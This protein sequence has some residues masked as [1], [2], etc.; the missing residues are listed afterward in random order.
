MP[1]SSPLPEPDPCPGKGRVRCILILA[2]AIIVGAVGG[3]SESAMM[4]AAPP[5]LVE[6]GVPSFVV[7]GPDSLGFSTAPSDMHLLPDG[8]IL[9]V[10]QRQIAIGDGTRWETYQQA[11]DQDAYIYAQ[12]AVDD[13]GRIYTGV[14]GKI[15]RID[16]GADALWR[17]VPV[18]STPDNDPYSRVVQVAGTWVWRSGGGTMLA[19][20]PGRP[21]QKCGLSAAVEDIFAVGNDLFASNGSSG[22]LYEL[23]F[24]AMATP[25]PSVKTVA[26]DIVTCSANYGAR[27]VIVGTTG[28]GIRTF[29]GKEFGDVVLPKILSEGSHINDICQVGIDLYAAA[30]DTKGIVFFERGGRIVQVL[31]GT[32]DHRLARP[33]RLVYSKNGVL[34][35]MLENAVACIQFPSPI[36]N[37]EALLP[38]HMNY[39]K[40]LRHDGKLWVLADG[41]LTRGIYDSN[42]C[43][44]RF[45]TD[46]PPGKFLWSIAETKGR[47]FA[48]NDEGIFVRDDAA[49]KLVAAG[50]VNARLGIGPA[51]SE[52][53]YFYV[54][55]DEVGWIQ[56]SAGRFTAQRIPVKGLGEVY[57]AVD[58][59]DGALWLELGPHR[60]ARVTFDGNKP[61]VRMFGRQDGLGNG[62]INIFVLDGRVHCTSSG[63][64]QRFDPQTQRFV[65]DRQLSRQFPALADSTGRPE[66]DSTGRLWFSRHG[67][68]CYIDD[69][70][71]G[72]KQIVRTLA[73][74]FEPTE[75]NMQSDGVIW[76]QGREHLI[77]YDPHMPSPPRIP[78]RAEITSVLLTASNLHLFTPGAALRPLPY[79]DNSLLI[80]FA[81]VTY[82]FGP[83]LSFEVMLE[84]AGNRWVS[85][86]A[87][88]SASFTRLKEGSYV[89]HVRPVIGETPGQE[90]RLAFTIQ[91]PWFRTR[92]AWL[93]YL[94]VAIGLVTSIAWFSS[95]MQRREKIRL[96][97]LV[98]ERTAEL[99]VNNAQLGRQVQEITEKTAAL[100]AS[101]ERYRKLNAELESRVTDRTAQLSRSNADLKREIAERQRAEQE[102]ERVHKQLVS[103]S[104]EAG[105]A[106]VATGV[107]H[108]VG[109]VLNSVNVSAGLLAERMHSSKINGVARLAQLLKEQGDGLG[110]FFTEDPRGRT[111]PGYLEQLAA[112]MEQERAEAGKEVEGLILNVNHIKEIVAMQQNYARVSG[113]VETVAL[114]EMV[115]DAIKIHGGAYA[116]HGIRLERDFEKLPP[117]TVDKHKLLQILV[118]LLHNSKYACEATNL[119]DKRVTI[120][121]KAASPEGAILAVEDTGTGIQPENMPRIFTQGFTTRKTGHGF[122]LHSAALA[123]NELGGRLTAHSDGPGRG[124][125]FTLWLP[126]QPPPSGDK[127]L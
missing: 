118:N 126:L 90:A 3:R 120:R 40:P 36:S 102:V 44:Q 86:G 75:F 5:G 110:R 113:V 77:R 28:S 61:V 55:R 30:V 125:T 52:G 94:A 16:L 91:P 39:A 22:G 41:H 73:L 50:I 84:G 15:C 72:E 19:W 89:F 33:R 106:E 101:E 27:Q 37:F 80:R 32:L 59:A 51:S 47:F 107:L 56:E 43:L 24:G 18:Y 58:T 17:L 70:K 46:T 65:E 117:I 104:H 8:R 88:G 98:A 79:S 66:R 7:F 92:L 108:N 48:T 95:Y 63:E 111:I 1:E 127:T 71:P 116:R 54:A 13:D 105:M 103:A 4:K 119:P 45:E 82:P 57:N 100:A 10:A 85:T 42:G 6:A 53:R 49:W 29:D 115:E 9:V 81:A 87:V 78:P 83:P 112:H 99:H 74:G 60:V 35:V 11:P 67:T 14:G 114:D 109:N 20:R 34:W 68:V 31:T 123:A 76:M 69:T 121:I 96:E 62:W 25:V 23:H 93:A 12:V 38:S 64:I 2:A 124:A 97:R 21:V 26:S 122:G